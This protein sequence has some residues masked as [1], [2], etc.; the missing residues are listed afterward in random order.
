MS[1]SDSDIEGMLELADSDFKTTMINMLRVSVGKSG[2]QTRMEGYRKHR[3]G[4]SEK[5]S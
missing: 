1:E 2:Q 4:K 3:N 5:E